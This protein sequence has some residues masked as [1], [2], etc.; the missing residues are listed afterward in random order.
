V[1]GEFGQREAGA[2][3]LERLEHVDRAIDRGHPV[4][5]RHE[6]SRY[7]AALG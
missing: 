6:T 5:V 4:P 3:A 7:D 2:R 1:L